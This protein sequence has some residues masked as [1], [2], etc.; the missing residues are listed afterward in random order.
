M[1]NTWKNKLK[2][3][4]NPTLSIPN[5]DTQTKIKG[6]HEKKKQQQQQPK[7]PTPPLPPPP[8]QPPPKKSS[9]TLWTIWNLYFCVAV[10][11]SDS[12]SRPKWKMPGT[13]LLCQ[14]NVTLYRWVS[15]GFAHET[16][17]INSSQAYN[18]GWQW[19]NNHNSLQRLTLFE[20]TPWSVRTKSWENILSYHFAECETPKIKAFNR[21]LFPKSTNLLLFYAN[22]LN[23]SVSV[24]TH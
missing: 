3:E 13:W 2:S 12:Y 16:L 4:Q 20:T 1:T 18:H 7:I 22:L 21:H 17:N 6:I 23:N 15:T 11:K 24:A 8:P 10:N 5:I 9:W 14:T 19:S